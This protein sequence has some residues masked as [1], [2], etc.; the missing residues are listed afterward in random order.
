MSFDYQKYR[1]EQKRA[2]DEYRRATRR[3]HIRV[4]IGV[5]AFLLALVAL[6]WWFVGFALQRE[7]ANYALFMESCL[8]DHKQYECMAMWRAGGSQPYPIFIPIPI[9]TGR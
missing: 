6:I 5:A 8:K 3:F 7:R 1:E 4:S 2:D 9:P